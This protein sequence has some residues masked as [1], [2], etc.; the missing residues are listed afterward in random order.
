[1][2]PAFALMFS[3]L[4]CASAFWM[5]RYG[6]TIDAGIELPASGVLPTVGAQLR[7]SAAIANDARTRRLKPRSHEDTK[8]NEYSRSFELSCLRGTVSCPLRRCVKLRG[9][10]T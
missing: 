9:L 4:S 3:V 7:V 8:I 2:L 1:M 5:S 10:V 6:S